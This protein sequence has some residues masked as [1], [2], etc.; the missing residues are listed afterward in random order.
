MVIA[1]SHQAPVFAGGAADAKR[2]GTR[3]ALLMKISLVAILAIAVSSNAGHAQ[4]SDGSPTDPTSTPSADPALG[5]TDPNG[6]PIQ[7]GVFRETLANAPVNQ[8]N[9]WVQGLVSGQSINGDLLTE[10]VTLTQAQCVLTY[11]TQHG[12]CANQRTSAYWS[13][14]PENT[15]NGGWNNPHDH[16]GSGDSGNGW[17]GNGAPQGGGGWNNSNNNQGS[18]NWGN[19]NGSRRGGDWQNGGNTQNGDQWTRQGDWLQNGGF[20]TA[21]VNKICSGGTGGGS[22]TGTSAVKGSG[23][24]K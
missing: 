5:Q 13:A 21:W 9:C 12:L 16:G 11:M 19:T 18:G 2:K 17:Q 23:S 3:M 7:Y 14:R 22:T 10:R 20:A 15:T 24:R 1:N 8:K 4:S 6:L